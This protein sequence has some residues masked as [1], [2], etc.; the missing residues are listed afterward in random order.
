MSV[1]EWQINAVDG[2]D[3]RLR[4]GRI[5]LVSVD[6]SAPVASGL[7]HVSADEITL[8][9]NL[10][11]D[12]LKTGNFL[13]QSA[14]RS[15]VTRNKAHELVYSGKGPVGEIWSVT[16]IARAGSIEVELDL[17]ITPI[18]SATAPM[19][20]IEIVGS[21]NMGTV[22][23]PIPGMG[24]VEDFSFDVDAKLALLTKT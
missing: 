18:A 8:T 10:A 5:G 6:V 12:Q 4:S 22:H 11:L 15:I 21:A 1:G 17:T 19:G 3:V 9:L 14:A 24:T 23:L 20:Q 7:L 2:A 16:G 13:L